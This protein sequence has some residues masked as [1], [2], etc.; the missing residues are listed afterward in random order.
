MRLWGGDENMSL[1]NLMQSAKITNN[2]CGALLGSLSFGAGIFL[3]TGGLDVLLASALLTSFGLSCCFHV[4]LGGLEKD[5]LDLKAED[6]LK[7]LTTNIKISGPVVGFLLIFT[8]IYIAGQ[9]EINRK[10]R[11]LSTNSDNIKSILKQVKIEPKGR[12]I[13]IDESGNVVNKLALIYPKRING[14]EADHSIIES[15]EVF[16]IDKHQNLLEKNNLDIELNA[17]ILEDIEFNVSDQKI[18]LG[19]F[20]GDELLLSLERLAKQTSE[21]SSESIGSSNNITKKILSDC[22]RLDGVCKVPNV[23]QVKISY[24]QSLENTRAYICPEGEIATRIRLG[25]RKLQ[26]NRTFSHFD[27]IFKIENIEEFDTPICKVNKNWIQISTNL[28]REIFP[29][30]TASKGFDEGYASFI[31]NK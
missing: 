9:H 22:H 27:K 26:L 18:N 7:K 3:L 17:Q 2:R 31:E 29:E 20:Q 15:K 14:L 19:F 21:V 10:N 5:E 13:V 11:L 8:L 30:G 16:D 24:S 23:V 6:A 4:L 25:N 12:F 1:V 28:G